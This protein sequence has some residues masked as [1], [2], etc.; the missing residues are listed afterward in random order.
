MDAVAGNAVAAAVMDGNIILGHDRQLYVLSG[1]GPDVF[2]NGPFLGPTLVSPA[3]GIRDARSLVLY[4]NGIIFKSPKGFW[5]LSRKL[6]LGYIGAAVE[7]FNDDT[8]SAATV[9]PGTTEII[10][11]SSDGT[12]LVFDYYYGQGATYTNHRGVD[13]RVLNGVYSYLRNDA[14]TAYVYQQ[15]ADDD[16]ARYSDNGVG[17]AF[18]FVGPW[19]KGGVNVQDYKRVWEFLVKGSF[20]GKNPIRCTIHTNYRT[21]SFNT[22]QPQDY[23]AGAAG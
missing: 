15:R 23:D 3:L 13:A 21:D 5:E 22:Y 1:N 16:T 12:T 17:Y 14:G 20:T 10:F 7:S 11:L 4:D 6:Q 19:W 9:I 2:G 8:C 18:K